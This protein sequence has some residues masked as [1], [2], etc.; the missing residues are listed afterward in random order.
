MSTTTRT[1]PPSS[2]GLQTVL[3]DYELKYTT[4]T[5]TRQE[6]GRTTGP[7]TVATQNPP[8]W[9]ESH[10][11]VPAYRPVDPGRLTP[12]RTATRN[13]V[14][15]T[16]IALVFMGVQA[17]ADWHTIWRATGEKVFGPLNCVI[18]GEW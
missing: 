10:R 5:A 11:R 15:A 8:G 17:Q 12:D 4:A 6:T 7:T 16:F 13:R 2:A 9:D 1:L 3:A 14:E 18:G